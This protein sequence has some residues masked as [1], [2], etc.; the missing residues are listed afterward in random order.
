MSRYRHLATG[1]PDCHAR[2]FSSATAAD[3]LYALVHDG[4]LGADAVDIFFVQLWSG[5][6][7][8]GRL[9]SG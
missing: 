4:V 2:Y 9:C 8:L 6:R 7:P 1:F 5:G 3:A